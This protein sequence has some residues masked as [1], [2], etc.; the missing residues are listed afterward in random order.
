MKNIVEIIYPKDVKN[1]EKLLNLLSIYGINHID[2]NP[3]TGW[4]Y[5]LDHFWLINQIEQFLIDKDKQNIV[6]LDIG[7][8]NSKF[9][10]FLEDYFGVFLIGIDRPKGFCKQ[11][12]QNNVN[13]VGDFLD[14]TGLK[15]NSV[16]LIIWLSSIEHNELSTIKTLYEKSMDLLKPKGVFL[17]TIP[18]TEQTH[19]FEQA[20]QT[21]LSLDDVQKIFGKLDVVG[22]PDEAKIQYQNDV[23][24]LRQRYQNRFG[25]FTENSPEYI[26]AGIRSE[27]EPQN[28]FIKEKQ[29]E[30][31]EKA[32][33][34]TFIPS[35][36]THV[37]WMAPIASQIDGFQFMIIPEIKEDADSALQNLGY[38]Y[39]QYSPGL[40][41][42]FRSS[43]VILG[44]DWGRKEREIIRECR[45]LG[46]TSICIQ[47]GP[48]HFR[49]SGYHLQN[50]DIAFLQ[51]KVMEKYIGS[52][53]AI[54]T[55]NPKYDQCNKSPL[56]K[57]PCVM[58]NC[59]FTYG[60]YEEYR[61]EWL[62]DIIRACE[63]LD[64]DYFI[65]QHPRDTGNLP[66]DYKII[67]SNAFLVE[68]QIKRSTILISRFS[69]LMY[70][71]LLMGRG[72][73][74]YDPMHEAF[75]LIK[76]N[77]NGAILYADDFEALTN[78]LK[79]SLVKPIDDD[80]LNEF[81]DL[82]CNGVNNH[83]TDN[84]VREIK[85]ISN[86]SIRNKADVEYSGKSHELLNYLIQKN[87][88]LQSENEIQILQKAN[89]RPIINDDK[90]I[91]F[92]K[93][94]AKRTG[95][96]VMVID[97]LGSLV[98]NLRYP[99]DSIILIP[100]GIKTLNEFPELANPLVEMSKKEHKIIL[101]DAND[102]FSGLSQ[103]KEIIKETEL[104]LEFLGY[105]K[106]VDGK[107]KYIT[108]LSNSCSDRYLPALENFHV[109]ALMSTFNEIDVI[110]S[111][112]QLLAQNGID[113]YIID[114]WSTDG[115]YEKTKQMIN[116]GVI[117]IERWPLSG[118]SDNY[119]RV[120]IQ[121][122]KEELSNEIEADWFIHHDADEILESPWKGIDLRNAIY[123]VDQQ[124]YNEIDF[125][126]LNFLPVG[127]NYQPGTSLLD[128]FKY[129]EFGEISAD[130][131]Q[132]KGWKKTN[133]WVNLHESGGC[134]PELS[135]RRIFPYKFLL[136]CY[137]I[138][139]QK[140]GNNKLFWDR[141]PRYTSEERQIGWNAHHD[142]FSGSNFIQS[143]KTLIEFDSDFYSDYLIERLSGIGIIPENVKEILSKEDV[144]V[145]TMQEVTVQLT[146][147]EL[148]LETL[149]QDLLEIYNR[150][151]RKLAL[152]LR[153]I[154]EA[155]FPD[156][157]FRARVVRKLVKR[158]MILLMKN[159]EKKDRNL[160]TLSGLFDKDWYLS[161][162]TDVAEANM[163]PLTHYLRFGGFEGR[164]PGPDFDS[165]W[166]LDTYKDVRKS[167]INPL[168]HYLRYGVV[169][170]KTTEFT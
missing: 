170:K 159:Q 52:Q 11:K 42:A 145:Q 76:E 19:W 26:A 149:N 106:D 7:C 62:E 115:T 40:F 74:Y 94:L 6:C 41:A 30:V 109:V 55:G 45:I 70:E 69:T 117:G 131:L 95:S 54:I 28:K 24:L 124:G 99:S 33:P 3:S 10:N 75:S 141:V 140:H 66:Q 64:V 61:D 130:F 138:R 133:K 150:V 68:D 1:E 144:H 116:E 164:D 51:G 22:E 86:E 32:F 73:V 163:D 96:K 15:E 81:L 155:I 102:S 139:S 107:L 23:L 125:T 83:A 165:S 101:V 119:D 8:G 71:A 97:D 43:L 29:N 47:E 142:I 153:R 134:N 143:P 151:D 25:E 85:R 80:L 126:V 5:A 39:L 93:F 147:K 21:N 67:K 79:Q 161:T 169:R 17:A 37:Q 57:K 65:S 58:I 123:I 49:E 114:N 48:L 72:V 158:R 53:N 12:I 154:R 157:S 60:I 128:Y 98:F 120:D 20:Q 146:E 156:G 9:H 46:I 108:I 63:A 4:H 166:Y 87:L 129:F 118:P 105:K 168:V 27:K 148:E 82:H 31:N 112:I 50:A 110:A 16:D 18:I 132:I 103:I 36:D 35:N 34:I 84:C 90:I 167:K 78:A 44:N 104:P 56:P 13:F 160:V 14:F 59:N 38:N 91:H 136:K 122:R 135:T 92:V 111:A 121:Q 162:N 77:N 2:T 137:P 89:L 88:L 127:N 113:V 152:F 100:E